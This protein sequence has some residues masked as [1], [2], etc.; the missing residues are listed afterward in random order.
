MNTAKPLIELRGV[1][2]RFG[3]VEVLRGVDVALERGQTTVVI[4]ESG[5]G[6][7]VLLKH[8]LGLIRPDRGEVYVDA[9]RIDQV[10]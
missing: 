9:Q 2:K 5:T 1:H 7:S 10:R 8:M 3:P 4:G 6:K